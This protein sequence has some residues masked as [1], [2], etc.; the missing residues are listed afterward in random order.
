MD[1]L[2]ATD[3]HIDLT[4]AFVWTVKHLEH[5]ICLYD[6]TSPVSL[7]MDAASSK[8][9]KFQDAEIIIKSFYIYMAM[10]GVCA[11]TILDS[12]GLDC[13]DSLIK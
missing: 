7:G 3:S 4:A 11:M 5:P 10:L 8:V 6:G 12:E 1:Y 2:K 13:V 9:T